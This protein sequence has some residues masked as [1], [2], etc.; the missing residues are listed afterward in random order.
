MNLSDRKRAKTLEQYLEVN[1]L[2]FTRRF[3]RLV[4]LYPLP[5][6][7]EKGFTERVNLHVILA[8]IQGSK[9]LPCTWAVTMALDAAPYDESSFSEIRKEM[10]A[11]KER[12][13]RSLRDTAITDNLQLLDFVVDHIDMLVDDGESLVG[14]LSAISIVM[15]GVFPVGTTDEQILNFLTAMEKHSSSVNLLEEEK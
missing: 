10:H 12:L 3:T 5:N 9:R 7:E 13:I 8:L 11:R 2:K 14:K 6:A 15:S 4:G 1:D